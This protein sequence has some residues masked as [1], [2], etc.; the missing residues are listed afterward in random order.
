MQFQIVRVQRRRFNAVDAS[1]DKANTVFIFG[2]LIVALEVL[3]VGSHVHKKDRRVQIFMGMLLG[4][5]GLLDG[6]HTADSR[7]VSVAPGEK[8]AG[9]HTLQP[10]YLFRGLLVGRPQQ[11]PL[12]RS[13]GTQNALE[14]HTGND[15]RIRAVTINRGNIRNKRLKPGSKDDGSHFDSVD[16]VL[17]VEVHGICRTEF[18]TGFAFAFLSLKIDAGLRVNGIFQGNRLRVLDVSGFSFVQVAVEFVV[19][20]FGTFLRTNAAGDAFFRVNIARPFA[21]RYRK[22][23][24]GAF[25]LFHISH[26]DELNIEMTPAFHQLR[27]ENT[28]G[29]I[30]GGKGLV[31]LRHAPAD[32]GGLFHQADMKT[33]VGQIQCGLGTGNSAAHN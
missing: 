25:H 32:G 1:T 14:F 7:T 23:T 24:G 31:Q 29:T 20:L 9:P 18:F 15:I 13:G 27:G 10:G 3:A 26:G 2:A 16:F 33:G 8:I 4:N 30:I 19:H 21:Y 11:V 17:L 6:V 28:H 22:T 5:N 12:V